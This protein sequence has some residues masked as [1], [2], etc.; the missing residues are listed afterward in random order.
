MKKQDH[1]PNIK[2]IKK[3]ELIINKNNIK[4]KQKKM[5]KFKI[6]NLKI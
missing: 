5:N 4:W 1:N 3:S 6:I 2:K